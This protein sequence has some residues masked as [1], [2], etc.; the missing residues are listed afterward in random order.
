MAFGRIFS[1]RYLRDYWE[2]SGQ[3]VHDHGTCWILEPG[4]KNFVNP[5]VQI[6]NL[7]DFNGFERTG[8]LNN[9]ISIGLFVN[10][11]F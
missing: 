1:L 6:V 8:A 4:P 3:M 9:P 7:T 2:H 5:I 10:M 11:K